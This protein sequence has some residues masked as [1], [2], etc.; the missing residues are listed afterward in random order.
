MKCC[1]AAALSFG[2]GLADEETKLE[3]KR[4]AEAHAKA[5]AEQRQRAAALAQEQQTRAEAGQQ[6]HLLDFSSSVCTQLI[7]THFTAPLLHRSCSLPC[8]HKSCQRVASSILQCLSQ[9]QRCFW[10]TLASEHADINESTSQ[11]CSCLFTRTS[12]LREYLHWAH[13]VLDRQSKSSAQNLLVHVMHRQKEC[14]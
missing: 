13:D 12:R 1:S 11:S 5:V 14:C 8:D 7:F 6:L 9:W 4:C 3:A 10:R 2:L